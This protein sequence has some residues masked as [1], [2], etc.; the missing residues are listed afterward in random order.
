MPAL[1][2][3]PPE[4]NIQPSELDTINICP[5]LLKERQLSVESNTE[6]PIKTTEIDAL[7][8]EKPGTTIDTLPKKDATTTSTIDPITGNSTKLETTN[9]LKTDSSTFTAEAKNGTVSDITNSV[10][11]PAEIKPNSSATETKVAT[12]SED[13][14]NTKNLIEAKTDSPTVETKNATATASEIPDS[15]ATTADTTPEKCKCTEVAETKNTTVSE[16]PTSTTK[17]AEVKAD[18]PATETKNTTKPAEVKADSSATDTKNTTVS[19]SFR[20]SHFHDKA[21]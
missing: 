7:L 18:S 6:L 2:I 20:N 12:V 15:N 8:I 3:P 21:C 11:T 13:S 9:N 17:P 4:K 14:T 5:E 1:I 16:I 19:D 10:T